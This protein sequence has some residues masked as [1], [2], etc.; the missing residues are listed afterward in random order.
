MATFKAVVL[1][2]QRKQDGTYNVKIRVTHNRQARYI[3]TPFYVTS[4]QLTRNMKIKDTFILDKTQEKISELR[5]A[6]DEIG[7]LAEDMSVE[8]FVKLLTN[9]PS[10]V[11]FIAYME[12]YAKQI[13]KERGNRTEQ[14]Y[15]VVVRSLRRFTKGKPLFFQDITK[16]VMADYWAFIGNL[17]PNTRASY[18]FDIKA[19]YKRAQR[20]FNN[21]DAGTIIVRHGVFDLIELPRQEAAN[22]MAFETVEQMQAVIDS[23]YYGTWLYDFV[24]DLFVLSFVL[25]GTN[26][27]DLV[28]L[29]KE[30]YKDGILTYRRK[31]VVRRLGPDAEIKI[32][33]PEVAKIIFEKYDGDPKYL[34]DFRGHPRTPYLGRYIH[35]TFQKA[36]LEPWSETYYERAGHR[37]GEGKYV[38]Y[39][40]RHSMATFARNVCKIDKATVHEM[41]NHASTSSMHNTDVY[42]RRDY[43]HL[44]EANEKLLALFDWSFYEK[45]KRAER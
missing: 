38:F 24:K 13:G 14:A 22:E 21:D 35:A 19:A 29:R 8:H 42:L 41:L 31:K 39:S 28:N 1:P 15:M 9:R 10:K 18:I 2:N 17:K 40:A 45:Q 16:R 44:W 30:D 26:L 34:I 25:F 33:V 3:A 20:E 11:D 37:K 12:N 32:Q 43:T 6:A 7:F 23:P 27:A 36:G 4:N 5:R